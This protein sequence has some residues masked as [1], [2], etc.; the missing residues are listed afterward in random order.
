M[1]EAEKLSLK[2]SELFNYSYLSNAYLVP[3]VL[4]SLRSG[5]KDPLK[6]E[7]IITVSQKIM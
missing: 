5:L 2:H 4:D 7:V 3:I 6:R 1:L